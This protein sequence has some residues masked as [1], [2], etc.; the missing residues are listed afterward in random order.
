[1][2]NFTFNFNLVKNKVDKKEYSN[3]IE[4]DVEGIICVNLNGEFYISKNNENSYKIHPTS[5]SCKNKSKVYPLNIDKNKSRICWHR[6][7]NK[8][9]LSN[10]AYL[11]FSAGLIA[12]G[13]VIKENNT[14]YFKINKVISNNS[15]KNCKEAFNYFKNNYKEIIK[16]IKNEE[17]I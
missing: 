12:I 5:Y 3:I 6:V 4:K 10:K 14:I 2:R 11:P 8:Q 16:N 1:M 13:D 15:N 17:L 9:E 7:E